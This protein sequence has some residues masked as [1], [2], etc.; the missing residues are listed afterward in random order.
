MLTQAQCIP[1]I[2]N[3]ALRAM[4]VQN[5]SNPKQKEI[6]LKIMNMNI[7]REDPWQYTS[8]EIAEHILK[9][10]RDTIGVYDLFKRE[11]KI[12]NEMMLKM[13]DEFE[14][15]LKRSS[16]PLKTGLIFAIYGNSID[17][18]VKEN[19]HKIVEELIALVQ[20][21]DEYIPDRVYKRF[22]KIIKDA[23]TILYLGD[24]AGEIVMDKL[25][26]KAIRKNIGADIYFVV[27]SEPSL[28]DVTMED[29]KKVGMDKMVPVI[30]NGIEGPLPGT[31]LSRCSDK[32]KELV[33]RCDLIISK[34]GGNFET[35]SEE[36][37]LPKPVCYLLSSKCNVYSKVFGVSINL[38]ILSIIE[39]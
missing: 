12:Q 10:I 15:L 25:F 1:C 5:L 7:L 8:A 11:R 32:V 14:D 38:P 2:L 29:A 16:D 4:R 30:E 34:G 22:I 17:V 27:R 23:K 13:Y 33:N 31:L 20:E 39:R 26:I 18:M 37:D 9:L 28:N 35:I 36:K 19:P 3:M 24:N 21:S 6:F